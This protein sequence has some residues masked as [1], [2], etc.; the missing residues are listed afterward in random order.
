MTV[1]MSLH[2]LQH[3][4]MIVKLVAN[5]HAKFPLPAD[6]VPE[7]VQLIVLL[8]DHAGMVGMYLLIIQLAL[9]RS[10]VRLISVREQLFSV[11]FLL[12]VGVVGKANGLLVRGVGCGA[13]EEG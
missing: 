7:P 11:G 5:L 6:A 8:P 10:Y 13:F 9:I 3:L 4:H 12:E 2:V 1:D